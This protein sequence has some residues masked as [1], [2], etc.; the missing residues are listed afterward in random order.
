MSC[1]THCFFTRICCRAACLW[2]SSC[3]RGIGGRKGTRN[4]PDSEPYFVRLLR[5]R[6]CASSI[7]ARYRGIRALH[8]VQTS[9]FQTFFCHRL[10]LVVKYRRRLLSFFIFRHFFGRN[11][12]V[13]QSE[14]NILLSVFVFVFK[15]A[16][17]GENNRGWIIKNR[18]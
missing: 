17:A 11:T 8:R 6:L 5:C 18:I 3:L 1:D 14:K 12:I 9:L 2:Y 7:F 13:A 15:N 10:R 16:E 4:A